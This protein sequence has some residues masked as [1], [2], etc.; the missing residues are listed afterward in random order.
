LPDAD[1]P[2]FVALNGRFGEANRSLI[3]HF[4]SFDRH[5][6]HRQSG[7]SPSWLDALVGAMH[8]IG[9][10]AGIATPAMDALFGLRLVGRVHELYPS[11]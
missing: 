10:R 11:P 6:I 8:E 7:R 4:R 2:G 5:K 3:G 9:Q 1:G